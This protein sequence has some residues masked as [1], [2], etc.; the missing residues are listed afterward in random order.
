MP[1]TGLAHSGYWSALAI[2]GLKF[3]EQLA[4][5]PRGPVAIPIC[6]A[7]PDCESTAVASQHALAICEARVS[8]LAVC[9]TSE[10]ADERSPTRA[11]ILPGLLSGTA[12]SAI[13]GTVGRLLW[14]LFAKCWRRRDREAP[15]DQEDGGFEIE[16]RPPLRQRRRS[17]GYVGGYIA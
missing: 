6:P 14:C 17:H 16:P 7:R 8:E 1:I 4:A 12:G 3:L 11:E 5:Q 13:G 2:V 15:I 10:E 9:R